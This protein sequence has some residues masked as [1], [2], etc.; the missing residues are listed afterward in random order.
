MVGVPWPSQGPLIGGR[1]SHVDLKNGNV[2]CRIEE[3][4][5]SHVTIVYTTMSLV[6]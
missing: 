5:M 2:A 1:M 6:T 3:I 4:V